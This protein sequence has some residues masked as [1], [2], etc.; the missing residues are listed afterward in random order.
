[1]TLPEIVIPQHEYQLLGTDVREAHFNMGLIGENLFE[2]ETKLYASPFSLLG[3]N[4]LVPTHIW[5]QTEGFDELITYYGGEDAEFSIQIADLGYE[6]GY[7]TSIAGCHMAHTKQVGAQSGTNRA[8]AHIRKRWPLWFTKFGEPIWAI[9]GWTR[10]P[11]GRRT[12]DA[13]ME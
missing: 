13:D 4:I 10:P 11:R 5:K 12:L 9:P 3:G 7:A 8:L 2:D 1:M 6:F